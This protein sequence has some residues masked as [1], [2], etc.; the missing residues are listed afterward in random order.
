MSN[1]S[2]FPRPS[3]LCP[4]TGMMFEEGVPG[5]DLRDYF[6]GQAIMG[7]LAHG[8][9]TTGI[10]PVLATRAYWIADQMLEARDV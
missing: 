4:Q 3:V 10:E 6:A 9:Y 7:L 5:M 1:P 2:V 8:G